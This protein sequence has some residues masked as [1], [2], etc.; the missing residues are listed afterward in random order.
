MGKIDIEKLKKTN[1]E[2]WKKECLVFPLDSSEPPEYRKDIIHLIA[3]T[4]LSENDLLQQISHVTLSLKDTAKFYALT[5]RFP[6]SDE[7]ELVKQIGIYNFG[8]AYNRMNILSRATS[9]EY[10][11]SS[12]AK[13]GDVISFEK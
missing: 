7:C 11:K 10:S 9:F 1:P 4:E 5:G 12:N 8:T 2:L 6:S 3:I 13:I